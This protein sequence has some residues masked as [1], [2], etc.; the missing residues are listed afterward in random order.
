[1]NDSPRPWAI[2]LKAL[3]LFLIF[4]VLFALF[5]IET[6]GL[7]LYNLLFPGRPR[8]PFGEN[9]IEAHNLSI[10][11]LDALF[12]SHLLHGEAKAADEMRILVIG[13]S[14]IWGTLLHPEETLSSRW[15]E[16]GLN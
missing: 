16:A 4:N 15:N 13:D 10:G 3:L 2:L 5:P 6:G 11:D 8:F 7:S 9:I 1:M 14:S 12:A